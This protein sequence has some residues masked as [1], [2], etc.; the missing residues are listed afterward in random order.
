[1]KVK[2]RV[3]SVVLALVMVLGLLPITGLGGVLVVRASTYKTINM[4]SDSNNPA[5]TKDGIEWDVDETDGVLKLEAGS[6]Q[7][8]S[9]IT[10][11]NTISVSG[12][13]TLDLNGYGILFNGSSGSVISVGNDANLALRDTA[14]ETRTHYITLTDGRGTEVA[15]SGS[16]S[17]TCIK[18]TGGYITGG[19]V[20]DDVGGGVCVMPS[21]GGSPT[22]TMSGGTI[23]GNIASTTGGGVYVNGGTFTMTNGKICSNAAN[24]GGG[25]FIVTGTFNLSGGTISENTANTSGGGVYSYGT[26]NL[27]GNSVIKD[28]KKGTGESAT[29]D[30]VYL[31]SG[32]TITVTGELGTNASIGVTY[33][34][35][36]GKGTFAEASSDYNSG[37]VSDTDAAK[38]TSDDSSLEVAKKTENEKTVLELKEKSAAQTSVSYQKATVNGTTV[39]FTDASCSDYTVV[40][41]QTTTWSAGWYVVNSDVTIDSAI[42]FSG[43]VNLILCDVATLTVDDGI[44]KS[45]DNTNANLTI[46]GQSE[47]T[48]ALNVTSDSTSAINNSYDYDQYG[49]NITINGG[50]ITAS[51]TGSNGHGIYAAGNITI[52]GGEVNAEAIANGNVGIWASKGTVTINGGKIT[53]KVTNGTSYGTG[54]SGSGVIISNGEVIA[55]GNYRAIGGNVTNEIAGTGWTDTEGASDGAVIEISSTGRTLSDYK[56]VEF[57]VSDSTPSGGDDSGSGDSGGGSTGGGGGSS[58]P[59]TPSTENYTIPV[60][61]ETS[62][63][64]GAEISEGTATVNEITTDQID[65]ATTITEGTETTT[66]T[67]TIDLSGAKQEVEAVELTKSTVDTLAETTAS[68]DNN[69]NTVT[70]ALTNASVELD[71]AALDAISQNAEDGAKVTIAVEEKTAEELTEEQ[72]TALT[73]VNV[74]KVISASVT[75]GTTEIHDFNGGSVKMT[76][77]NEIKDNRDKNFFHIY[78]LDTLGALVRYITEHTGLQAIY[79][80]N[81]FS[82]YVLVYDETDQN[83]NI[84][85]ISSVEL[86]S[87]S[88]TYTGKKKSAVVAK[89]TATTVD[90]E[91]EVPAN[92]YTVTGNSAKT[93]GTYEIS[94]KANDDSGY[95]GNTS[96]IWKIKKGATTF[97]ATAKSVSAKK[98][99]TKKQTAAVKVSGL[100]TGSSKPTYKIQSV[101]K[102]MKKY[103]SVNKKGVVTVKKGCKKCTIK[104]LV[105]SKATKNRKAAK[106]VVTIKVK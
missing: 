104:V 48:G 100:T 23:I 102:K 32:K 13:V 81:H 14:S 82:D 93:V 73:D 40:T 57:K 80:T 31:Y 95:R 39:E 18:V 99:K 15:D 49:G 20:S 24:F 66:D 43:D 85:P 97:R 63:Q 76:V 98:V 105:T 71:A 68:S 67:L 46:Y 62:V 7:L 61:N 42:N 83:E 2:R 86:K 21:G 12:T 19:T 25:V 41:D 59:S 34:G 72:Q 27:F 58:T 92:A 96:T 5:L 103:V 35:T 16:E 52:N 64:V 8:T 36:D 56:K 84:A 44:K 38:F 55:I 4:D 65:K 94:V 33:G 28:N 77:K 51:A 78:Y 29:N 89:V 11:Q 101:T 17:D 90:G 22:F 37:S 50:K 45:Q 26:F 75:S 79:R 3:L 47:G 106:K 53:A 54:I 60:E 69:V 74:E 1:M 87:T 6:Y 91:V 88:F 10:T 70:V 30:N 9:D